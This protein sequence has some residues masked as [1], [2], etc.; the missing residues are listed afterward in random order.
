MGGNHCKQ[1][2]LCIFWFTGLTTQTHSEQLF[3]IKHSESHGR[4]ITMTQYTSFASPPE[5]Q[6]N[7]FLWVKLSFANLGK[8]VIF[9]HY[10]PG[11]PHL[12]MQSRHTAPSPDIRRYC[13]IRLFIAR[14]S[15]STFKSWNIKA[16]LDVVMQVMVLVISLVGGSY[17]GSDA[18]DGVRRR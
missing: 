12:L 7:A 9:P 6:H 2:F 5:A 3:S 4:L 18:G 13:F 17:N 16:L 15:S 10:Y 1:L 8:Q 14:L 11:K